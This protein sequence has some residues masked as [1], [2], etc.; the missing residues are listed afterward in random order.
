[1]NKL[2]LDILVHIIG[3]KKDAKSAATKKA[4]IA[5]EA[6]RRKQA[7]AEAKNTKEAEAYANMSIEELD[8]ILAGE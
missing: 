5:A 8:A 3:K 6:R 7:A 4:A 2:R 1:M